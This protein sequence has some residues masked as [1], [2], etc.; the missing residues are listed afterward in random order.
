MTKKEQKV[1]AISAEIAACDEL[2]GD[3]S[4]YEN[5]PEK[6][7]QLSRKRGELAKALGQAEADWLKASD[8]YEA[9]RI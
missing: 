5:D 1:V 6:A 4:L 7:S 2:L 3:M 9:A 8:V